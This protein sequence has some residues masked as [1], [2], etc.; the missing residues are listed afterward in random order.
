M[1]ISLKQDLNAGDEIMLTLHFEK[2]EDMLLKVPVG[3]AAEMG[4]SGMEGHMP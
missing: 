1:L 3:D 4:T 2:H